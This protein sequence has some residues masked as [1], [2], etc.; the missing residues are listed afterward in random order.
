MSW[1]GLVQDWYLCPVWG[2]V[3]ELCLVLGIASVS[4]SAL[5]RTRPAD[6]YPGVS[7][8]LDTSTLAK[9]SQHALNARIEGQLVVE[10]LSVLLLHI[11][12]L[13][14]FHWHS[15][16]LKIILCDLQIWVI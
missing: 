6:N 4:G 2:L 7:I 3:R 12:A 16:E 9:S 1:L 5:T 10:T 13:Y 15:A 14:C 8:P 11:L